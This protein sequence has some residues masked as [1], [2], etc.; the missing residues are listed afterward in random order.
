M[1]KYVTWCE[2]FSIGNDEIDRQHKKLFEIANEFY[3]S[4]LNRKNGTASSE[5]I[6]QKLIRYAQKHF[7]AEEQ[8]LIS[9]NLSSKLV[10]HHIQTHNKLIEDI[11]SINEKITKNDTTD[12]LVVAKFIREW[13]IF[14]VLVEDQ[15]LRE[16]L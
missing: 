5:K 16:V 3:D 15:K 8:M 1:G 12:V 6:L 9:L 11:F 10:E 4:T 2:I 14:H 13:L 7:K